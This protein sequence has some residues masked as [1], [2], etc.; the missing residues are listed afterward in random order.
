VSS[1]PSLAIRDRPCALLV[2]KLRTRL[3]L[4]EDCQRYAIVDPAQ[5][6][7]RPHNPTYK[8]WVVSLGYAKHAL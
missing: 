2:A 6:A 5:F 1:H 3:A 8:V 7:I 4:G